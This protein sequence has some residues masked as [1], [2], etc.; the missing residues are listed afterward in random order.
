MPNWRELRNCRDTPPKIFFT[1]Y[2]KDE[3]IAKAICG[4][5]VVRDNCL[6]EALTK[7]EEHGIWGGLNEKE[8][9]NFFLRKSLQGR[10]SFSLPHNIQHDNKH[11][12]SE[13]LSSPSY[14]ST[15]QIH[16]PPVSQKVVVW[17]GLF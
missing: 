13:F 3:E 14:N 9:F 17:R 6:Q 10:H 15:P 11:P 16:T 7:G 4:K 2:N 5:C 8:R 1:G 12:A